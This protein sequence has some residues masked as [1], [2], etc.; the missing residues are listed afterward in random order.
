MQT[1]LRDGQLFVEQV[2][3]STRTPL[4]S[5]LFHGEPYWFLRAKAVLKIV[6]RAAG[7]WQDCHGCDD[8]PGFRFPLYQACFA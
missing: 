7:I 1:I 5:L 4:V 8:R 2:R 3:T 6:H